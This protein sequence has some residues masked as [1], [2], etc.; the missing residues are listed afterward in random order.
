MPSN[1]TKHTLS[2]NDVCKKYHK[3]SILVINSQEGLFLKQMKQGIDGILKV[4]P[5]MAGP[6]SWVPLVL[7]RNEHD[8]IFPLETVDLKRFELEH[9]AD[10]KQ[11]TIHTGSYANELTRNM[12]ALAITMGTD[13]YF[14]DHAYQP[15]NEEGRKLIAHELT[16]V[17]QFEKG[18]T[19][20]REDVEELEEAAEFAES[21]EMYDDD[22]YTRFKIGQKIYKIQK[23]QMKKFVELTAD[24]VEKWVKEQ[25]D[26][27]SDEKY[28]ALLCDYD[29]WLNEGVI[30]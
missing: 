19:K 20:K 15:E 25:K 7:R 17:D 11:A 29:Q 9:D 27:L 13:I 12:N 6:P 14:R 28:L 22:P 1:I 18:L 16:H 23:S 5:D 3:L 8:R 21:Q 4:N 10:I 24:Y 30:L 26:L 2:F